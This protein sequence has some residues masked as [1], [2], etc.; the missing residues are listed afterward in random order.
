[1]R[2]FLGYN[3]IL[4]FLGHQKKSALQKKKIEHEETLPTVVATTRK[5]IYKG[6]RNGVLLK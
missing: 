3:T 5:P 1:M 2:L 6:K 4:I